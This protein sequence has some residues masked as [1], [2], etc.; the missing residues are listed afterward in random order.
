[1]QLVELVELEF[2]HGPCRLT[3]AQP[4]ICLVAVMQVAGQTGF[5]DTDLCHDEGLPGQLA[6]AGGAFLFDLRKKNRRKN[7][8][9]H[10]PI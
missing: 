1:M 3:A 4:H 10:H 9:D 7:Y 2:Y 6:L 5:V 8:R